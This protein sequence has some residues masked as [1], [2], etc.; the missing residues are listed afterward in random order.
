MNF[1]KVYQYYVIIFHIFL[2]FSIEVSFD[3]NENVNVDEGVIDD[4]DASLEEAMHHPD[5]S[6]YNSICTT[7]FTSTR[8]NYHKN[9]STLNCFLKY[10]CFCACI[11]KL[12][13]FVL[14]YITGSH[15]VFFGVQM[16]PFILLLHLS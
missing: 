6:T 15:A 9:S 13:L 8:C 7:L 3:V 1:F 16:L 11:H 10:W 12:C 5:V 2:L 14:Y 4:E